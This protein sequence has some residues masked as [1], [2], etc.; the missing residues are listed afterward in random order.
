MSILFAEHFETAQTLGI[1]SGDTIP[2]VITSPVYAGA[3]ALSLGGSNNSHYQYTIPAT[4]HGFFY[5][6]FRYNSAATAFWRAFDGTTQHLELGLSGTNQI[7][8]R[9]SGVTRA[10]GTFVV[11]AGTYVH[12]GIEYLI[13]DTTGLF[14]LYINGASSPD[15][16]FTGDTRNGGGAQITK[17]GPSMATEVGGNAHQWDNIVVQ[18]STGSAP[19]NAFLACEPRLDYIAPDAA[20]DVSDWTVSG[21]ATAWQATN[22]TVADG[23]TTRVE[24]STLNQKVLVNCASMPSGGTIFAVCPTAVMAKASAGTRLVGLLDKLGSTERVSA[25]IAL[26]LAYAPYQIVN[27]RDPD[28]A[29]WT[30]SNVNALQVGAKVTL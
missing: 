4:V 18:D 14:K 6:A 25:D 17:I 21:A 23:D 22:E 16:N 28:G 9:S 26:T 10:T 5:G 29:A 13:D 12:L 1:R 8:F 30:E 24:S 11:A 2:S 15:I 27:H 3:R 19:E 7:Q 20:G